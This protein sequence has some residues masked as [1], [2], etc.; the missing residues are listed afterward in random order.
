MAA[1]KVASASAS[2]A[3]RSRTSAVARSRSA[4]ASSW[5]AVGEA[6]SSA[7]VMRSMAAKAISGLVSHVARPQIPLVRAARPE[8]VH[9]AREGVLERSR[10][11]GGQRGEPVGQPLD[12]GGELAGDL[13][14]PA[15]QPGQL[16]HREGRLGRVD[17]D[18]AEQADGQGRI[19]QA[20][21]D[22]AQRARAD[23]RAERRPDRRLEHLLQVGPQRPRPGQERTEV[24]R[25]QI[26][27]LLPQAVGQG[28]LL[29]DLAQ[30]VG[31]H[32]PAQALGQL[33]RVRL[34]LVPRLGD[35]G[36][37]LGVGVEVGAVDVL[38]R[39]AGQARPHQADDREGVVEVAAEQ[40]EALRVVRGLELVPVDEPEHDESVT[41]AGRDRAFPQERP[42]ERA[43]RVGEDVGRVAAGVV[44]EPRPH[45]TIREPPILHAS[46][47][48][49]GRSG[50]PAAP[51]EPSASARISAPA[52][53]C[54]LCQV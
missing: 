44:G 51:A 36:R 31:G 16:P 30:R 21:R 40:P 48:R 47:Q 38:R 11:V 41:G 32:H 15:G 3:S 45:A 6:A 29:V 34:A 14:R 9:E 4:T 5:R 27:A 53:R 10:P 26:G 42:P 20:G 12:P 19:T 39:R 17:L 33:R 52:A 46:P 7:V 22:R 35:V 43:H 13:V 54:S 50:A 37:D 8:V 49:A 1:S 2:A 24:E 25:R 28:L 23:R 18:A